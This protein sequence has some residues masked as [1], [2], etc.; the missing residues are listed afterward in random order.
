MT[1]SATKK[2]VRLKSFFISVQLRRK[3]PPAMTQT[4]NYLVKHEIGLSKGSAY[5]PE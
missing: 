4:M 1:S 3:I 2:K 5:P